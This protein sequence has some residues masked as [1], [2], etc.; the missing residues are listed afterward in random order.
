VVPHNTMNY[1]FSDVAGSLFIYDLP[2]GLYIPWIF[3]AYLGT[4]SSTRRIRLA[5]WFSL[6][7]GFAISWVGYVLS[8]I[9]H[10]RTFLFPIVGFSCAA[11]LRAV[12]PRGLRGIT[13]VASQVTTLG[14]VICFYFVAVP[15]LVKRG[16]DLLAVLQVLVGF[17]VI[18]ETV[19]FVSSRAAFKLTFEVGGVEQ[20]ELRRQ[21]G[22]C[23][24]MWGQLLC[25]IWLRF[26]FASFSDKRTLALTVV[27]Q[28]LQEIVMR[29][30]FERRD[31]FISRCC[32]VKTSETVFGANL[33]STRRRSTRVVGLNSAVAPATGAAEGPPPSSDSHKQAQAKPT[34]RRRDARKAFLSLALCTDM[35]AEYIA[36]FATFAALA[37][38][39]PDVRAP[40]G[41][42]PLLAARIL[43]AS[44]AASRAQVPSSARLRRSVR[45]A[46]L[47]LFCQ[48]AFPRRAAH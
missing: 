38:A 26:Q 46:R 41:R 32:R 30:T 25:A 44:R 24:V 19:R 43:T 35:L 6:L 31:A 33:T 28:N 15:L 48:L 20:F 40:S 21:H 3:V 9:Q 1:R 42:R 34:V 47:C 2:L 27:A 11:A 5:L 16:D 37:L 45:T 12:L 17:P 22:F 29:L 36:I 18:K 23:V 14:V 7:V 13:S 4:S 39:A 10:F 8:G